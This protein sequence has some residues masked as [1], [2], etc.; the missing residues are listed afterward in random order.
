MTTI[1]PPFTR[2]SAIQKIQ[3]AYGNENCEVAADSLMKRRLA[4]IN[5]MPI[6]ED[7]RKIH[8]PLGRRRDDHPGLTD[9]G[10]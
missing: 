1:T 6:S 7:E 5:D 8:W 4:S 3:L 10:L 2:E 9:L